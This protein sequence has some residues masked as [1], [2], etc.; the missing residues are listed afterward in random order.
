MTDKTTKK[1]YIE[2]EFD[3]DGRCL[4]AKEISVDFRLPPPVPTPM[5]EHWCPPIL[6]GITGPEV[7][8]R[9]G[10]TKEST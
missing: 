9:R 4:S 5:D 3:S 10:G 8:V 2:A 6:K 1:M 7:E